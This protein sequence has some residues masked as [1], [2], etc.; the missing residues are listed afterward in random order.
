MVQPVSF[1][2]IVSDKMEQWVMLL[3]RSFAVQGADDADEIA[4]DAQAAHSQYGERL[5]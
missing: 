3:W 5:H 2:W 1:C 4:G